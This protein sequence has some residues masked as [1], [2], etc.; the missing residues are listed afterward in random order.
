MHIYLKSRHEE[1]KAKQNKNLEQNKSQTFHR[2]DFVAKHS[3]GV[4]AMSCMKMVFR[5]SRN[6]CGSFA[7][8]KDRIMHHVVVLKVRSQIH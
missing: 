7:E 5:W 8:C 4:S 3:Q 6:T 2:Q 1:N